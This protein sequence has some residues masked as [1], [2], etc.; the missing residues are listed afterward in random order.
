MVELPRQSH[1][2]RGQP[3]EFSPSQLQGLQ[4]LVTPS[5]SKVG[6]PKEGESSLVVHLD[7]QA[8]VADYN[9]QYIS[10]SEVTGISSS[11]SELAKEPK[12]SKPEFE[13]PATPT[14][15]LASP[16]SSGPSSPRVERVIT[17]NLPSGLIAIE[18]IVTPEEEGI[19]IPK[20][21]PVIELREHESIF[22]SPPRSDAWYL[23]LTNFLE[24]PRLIFSP[25]FIPFHPTP[26][27][28][29]PPLNMSIQSSIFSQSPETFLHG[30][31]SVPFGYQSLSGTFSG[32]SPQ[33]SQQGL[34]TGNNETKPLSV[35]DIL[36]MLGI[37]PNPQPQGGQLPPGGQPQGPQISPRGKPQGTQLP[38]G[39]KP[40]GQYIPMGQ[41]IPQVE[42]QT[43][44]VP[45]GQPQYQYLPQGQPQ[46]QY[47]PQGYQPQGQYPTQG[48]H[49]P[50]G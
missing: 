30:G 16:T 40:Q 9:P 47:M 19:S 17:Q 15:G 14:S 36:M 39:G 29:Y 6:S 21:Q 20:N 31:P 11:T 37:I 35:E 26:R 28:Y 12:L 50:S 49:P 23:S 34:L 7:Y 46:Y 32:T 41:Y 22:Y 43:Q 25:P 10:F 45:Q 27:G 24:N 8:L 1:R 3:P 44:Y 42:T 48:F 13:P 38:P 4:S 5:E 2:L 33:P 18:E